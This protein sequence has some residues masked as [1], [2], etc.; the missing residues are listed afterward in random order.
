MCGEGVRSI[1]LLCIIILQRN[2]IIVIV[3]DI[4]S[5]CDH[6]GPWQICLANY[7]SRP[8]LLVDFHSSLRVKLLMWCVNWCP[9]Q[10]TLN[11]M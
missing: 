5:C 11:I 3:E 7:A 1:A 10:K 8:F 2:S 4:C 9:D 6:V